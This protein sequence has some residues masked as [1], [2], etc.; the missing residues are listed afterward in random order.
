MKRRIWIL[1]AAIAIALAGS[2]AR[3]E[4]DAAEGKKVFRKCMA[5]HMVGENAKKRVGPPLNNLFGRK[6]GTFE[7]FKY[8][9]VMKALGEAGLDWDDVT[10][11]GY[12]TKTRKWLKAKA[13]ELGLN[14]DDLAKCRGKMVFAGLKK[15][16]D[17]ANLIAYLKQF[18]K[19]AE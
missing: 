13:P 10:F 12:I 2:P 16:A 6:A 1:V 14:C 8:S 18:S 5:C 4:G 15:D 7:G 3:A 9:K 11:D 19:P 17:R